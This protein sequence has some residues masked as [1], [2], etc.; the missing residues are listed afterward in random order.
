M[1]ALWMSYNSNMFKFGPVF[2]Y[3][4]VG[5]GGMVQDIER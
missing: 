2:D 4:S 3:V 5:Y 1:K